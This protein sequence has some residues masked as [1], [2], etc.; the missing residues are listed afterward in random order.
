M[1]VSQSIEFTVISRE[2]TVISREKEVNLR[3]FTF[4]N[5]LRKKKF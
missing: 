5:I 3:E 2:I 1:L 4:E